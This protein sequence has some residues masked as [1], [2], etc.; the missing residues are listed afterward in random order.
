MQSFWKRQVCLLA[1]VVAGG[2]GS[3]LVGAEPGSAPSA[4]WGPPT[5]INS[6]MTLDFLSQASAQLAENADGTTTAAV[7]VLIGPTVFLGVAFVEP[8]GYA[9]STD[10]GPGQSG[11]GSASGTAHFDLEGV[12]AF[13]FVSG[14]P[15]GPLDV[16]VDL[17]VADP[18]NVSASVS[19]GITT[20]FDPLTGET[21]IVR[22]HLIGNQAIGDTAGSLS[23]SVDDGSGFVTVIDTTGVLGLVGRDT[24]LLVEQVH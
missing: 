20:N 5:Q 11:Q 1:V 6:I 3:A 24:V 4:A 2:G 7:G 19:Q 13:D 9:I 12:F 17:Q 23:I 15:V 18:T 8:T 10:F 21:S 16:S 14:M 22:Q